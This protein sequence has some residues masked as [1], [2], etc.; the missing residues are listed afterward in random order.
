ME[1][2]NRRGFMAGTAAALALKRGV[3]V[4]GM[5]P[6][7]CRVFDAHGVETDAAGQAILTPCKTDIE[8]RIIR[9]TLP[10]RI[11]SITCTDAAGR[12]RE[13]RPCP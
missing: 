13:H 4:P 6:C 3:L 11:E 8:R 9:P 10:I 2:L 1:S 12:T 5:S 7:P